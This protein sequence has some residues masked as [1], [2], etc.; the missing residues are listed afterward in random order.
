M[1]QEL[2]HPPSTVHHTSHTVCSKKKGQFQGVQ[3]DDIDC[4][5]S[6]GQV[7][8]NAYGLRSREVVCWGEW[9][10]QEPVFCLFKLTEPYERCS[11]HSGLTS[12]S[13]LQMT[14]QSE[15]VQACPGQPPS[16]LALKS[17]WR[18]WISVLGCSCCFRETMS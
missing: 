11:S 10:G 3:E 7:L 16:V 6:Q 4:F 15:A 13:A 8:L 14:C 18:Q 5:C 9:I 17:C 1:G 12:Q 2:L